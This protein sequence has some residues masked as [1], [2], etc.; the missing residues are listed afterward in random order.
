MS[1]VTGR[2][3]AARMPKKCTADGRPPPEQ[4]RSIEISGL[5]PHGKG[6]RNRRDYTAAAKPASL[7][8]Y[9]SGTGGEECFAQRVPLA[10]R[11]TGD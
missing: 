7:R 4:V 6:A 2:E 9:E 8:Q 3:K 1:S 5:H 10:R 11:E